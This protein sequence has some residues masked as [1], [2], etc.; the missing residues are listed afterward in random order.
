MHLKVL[1]GKW[2]PFCLS[3]NVLKSFLLEDKDLFVQYITHCGCWWPGDTSSQGISSHGPH[4]TDQMASVDL[5]LVSSCIT[6][7]ITFTSHSNVS[8]RWTNLSQSR[9]V[10]SNHLPEWQPLHYKTSIL[11]LIQW[12]LYNETMTR[13]R[14]L[15]ETD[16]VDS[17]PGTVFTKSCL[18]SLS[19]KTTCHER[20]QNLV[21]TLYRFHCI[22]QTLHIKEYHSKLH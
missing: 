21:V 2:R 12:K 19:W 3:L 4:D 13:R 8:S 9:L 5:F 18:F 17:L 6:S 10:S 1:S 7:P 22:F 11:S 16:K 15:P 14:V 20:P